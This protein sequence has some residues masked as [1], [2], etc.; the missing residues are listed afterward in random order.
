[1][2]EPYSLVDVAR[3]GKA[4]LAL[5]GLKGERALTTLAGN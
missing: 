1:M 3:G 4:R 5:E 2:C